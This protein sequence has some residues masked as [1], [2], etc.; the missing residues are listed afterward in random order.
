MEIAARTILVKAQNAGV[1]VPRDPEWKLCYRDSD[2]EDSAPDEQGILERAE[3]IT[4]HVSRVV[5]PAFSL[6]RGDG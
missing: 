3:T 6:D 2:D 1:S 4:D 5:F